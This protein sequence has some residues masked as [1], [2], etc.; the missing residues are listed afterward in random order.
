MGSMHFCEGMR[1]ES[2]EEKARTAAALS[3]SPIEFVLVIKGTATPMLLDTLVDELVSD[4]LE[5][6]GTEVSSEWP[7]TGGGVA[8]GKAKFSISKG[9]FQ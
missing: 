7:G 6:R 8:K 9:G 1:Q 3:Q 2:E 4:A 5:M